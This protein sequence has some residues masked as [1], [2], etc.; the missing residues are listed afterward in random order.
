MALNCKM[1]VLWVL[2]AHHL[3]VVNMMA[4]STDGDLDL[5]IDH[6]G[7]GVGK[8]PFFSPLNI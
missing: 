5:N 3:S 6:F 8:Q 4:K 7:H 1:I 2:I